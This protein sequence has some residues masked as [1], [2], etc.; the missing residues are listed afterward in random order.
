LPDAALERRCADFDIHPTG[1][2]PGRG[3]TGATG[4]AAEI[5]RRVMQPFEAIVAALER[6]GVNAD[7]RSLRVRPAGLSWEFD[8]AD[9]VLEFTLPPGAYATAVLR[10]LVSADAA[11][12]SR[13]I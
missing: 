8:G 10:E 13:D 6:A 3:G 12:I 9:L 1:P 11:S 5:E 7:R 4:A 2:L